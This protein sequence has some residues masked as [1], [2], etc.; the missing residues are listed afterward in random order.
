MLI[1]K[2]TLYSLVYIGGIASSVAMHDVI[3]SA[4]TSQSSAGVGTPMFNRQI[5]NRSLKSD[6]LPI[7]PAKRQVNDKEPLQAPLNSKIGSACKPPIDVLVR[8]FADA[9]ANKKYA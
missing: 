4:G 2:L 5:A 8:Y 1:K 9:R 7:N 3:S 6:R